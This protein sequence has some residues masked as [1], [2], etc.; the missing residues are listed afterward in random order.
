MGRC[1]GRILKLTK[2]TAE[3]FTVGTMSNVEAAK[4]LLTQKNFKFVLPGIFADEALEKFF[5][6][7]RQRSGG[8]F[9]IDTIDILAAA[10][11]KNLQTLIKK[12]IMPDN[13]ETISCVCT[14][15]SIEENSEVLYELSL[16][17]TEELLKSSDTLK[18][19]IIYIAGYLVHKFGDNTYREVEEGDCDLLSS[20]FL[21]EL[22]R[23]SLSLPTLSTVYFVH[24]AHRLHENLKLRCNKHFAELL[25]TVNAPIA[26]S[27]SACI[28]LAN[29]IMKA[30]VLN[31]SDKER[32]LGCLRHKEK[33]SN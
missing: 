2:Q 26:G 21:D 18:H 11:I 4:Y 16:S 31:N 22:N 19:K 24:T 27:M 25:S 8:S 33:L 15:F 7:A 1:K 20:E 9:Y 12:G 32:A 3:A 17:D 5:G 23:G 13:N 29:I 10:K 30:F 28:V 6:Q 14:P